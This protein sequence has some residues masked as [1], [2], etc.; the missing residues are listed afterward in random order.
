MDLSKGLA[1]VDKNEMLVGALCGWAMT[2]MLV[3]W[4][5]TVPGFD[6]LQRIS[7]EGSVARIA[8]TD[9]AGKNSLGA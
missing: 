7:L 5:L 4:N 3:I 1:G 8:E 9:M 6:Q 2:I